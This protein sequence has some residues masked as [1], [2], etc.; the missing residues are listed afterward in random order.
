MAIRTVTEWYAYTERPGQV[1]QY[2]G[3][4]HVSFDAG[5][6]GVRL[7]A[8]CSMAATLAENARLKTDL[9]AAEA[10][11]ECDEETE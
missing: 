1:V 4:L 3:V 6:E 11:A 5:T 10:A 7:A 8:V 9:D 2:H